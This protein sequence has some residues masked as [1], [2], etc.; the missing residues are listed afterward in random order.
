MLAEVDR[1]LKTGEFI[2]G[3]V[4]NIRYERLSVGIIVSA[5][6]ILLPLV[7]KYGIVSA[8]MF[9]CYKKDFEAVQGFNENMLMT[10][11][12]D[13]AKRL[14]Q[15]GKKNGKKFGTIRKATLFT[16]SRKFDK[17]GDWV[18]FK[19]PEVIVGY[20]T[21]GKNRKTADFAYYENQ[22]R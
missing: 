9:W 12:V 2:G 16:S 13:F 17:F 10:E 1:L 7:I 20:W 11:D 8:G 5:I 3:A 6:V 18:V 15:W 21:G 4:G 19:S 14:K 22:P